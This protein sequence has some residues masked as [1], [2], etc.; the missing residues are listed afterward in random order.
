MAATASDRHIVQGCAAI[1]W[2]EFHGYPVSI[3]DPETA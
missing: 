2:P 3:R 1:R